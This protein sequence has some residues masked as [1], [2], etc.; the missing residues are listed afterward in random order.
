MTRI[1]TVV[2]RPSAES[3]SI[4]PPIESTIPLQTA[5]PRPNPPNRRE[6]PRDSC[7]NAANNRGAPRGSI[8]M[9]LS[10]TSMQ[11]RTLSPASGVALT[12]T[13]AKPLSVNFSALSNR[14]NNT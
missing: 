14:F 2:P 8:P 9:P 10:L 13:L 1:R 5:N 11:T 7:A 6:S 4:A 12:R 3:N